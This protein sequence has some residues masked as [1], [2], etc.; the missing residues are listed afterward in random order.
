MSEHLSG[1]L[2]LSRMP[3]KTNYDL[4]GFWGS[5]QFLVTGNICL[6]LFEEAVIGARALKAKILSLQKKGFQVALSIN[7]KFC[8]YTEQKKSKKAATICITWIA[9]YLWAIVS[10][11][12]LKA[13]IQAK[14][15]AKFMSKLDKCPEKYA[16]L[17]FCLIF[18]N[19]LWP[20]SEINFVRNFWMI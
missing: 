20:G 15:F 2:L 14:K 1:K 10:M 13:Q 19:C 16:T 8:G 6:C 18:M 12:N 9:N 11:N 17:S 5:Q 4:S 7:P 3:P